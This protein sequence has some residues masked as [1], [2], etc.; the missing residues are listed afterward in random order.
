[1]RVHQVRT[2]AWRIIWGWR[3]TLLGVLFVAAL[4]VAMMAIWW[5]VR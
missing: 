5:L 1:M 4:Y 2:Q 3:I